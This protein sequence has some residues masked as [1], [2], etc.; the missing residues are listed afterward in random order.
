MGLA[1]IYQHPK[2]SEPHPLHKIHP[3]L[4]RKRCPVPTF[5]MVL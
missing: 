2:T 5:R 1:P 4:L 3:Y